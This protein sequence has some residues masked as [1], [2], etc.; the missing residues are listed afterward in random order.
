M[1]P[2]NPFSKAVV[3][4]QLTRVLASKGFAHSARMARFLRFT[5]ERA[6]EGAADQLKEYV[7][8]I[9]VFDRKSSYDPRVDPIVRVEARRLRSKLKNYYANE[10]LTDHVI[11]EF[12]TG[13]YAPQFLCGNETPA[14]DTPKPRSIAVLPFSNL[15]AEPDTEYFSD[16]LTEE[17]IHG[18]TKLEGLMVVA[19]NS[20]ARLKGEPHNWSEIGR[21]LNVSTV[22]VGSVRRRSAIGR[23][24]DVNDRPM[25]RT[26]ANM[27]SPACS[28]LAPR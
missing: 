22:L 18:L 25:S 7:L 3:E 2:E 16:G 6:L 9:E 19:W 20:A 26:N 17:L 4:N 27:S 14:H 5:V 24:A 8:G 10:G 15:S 1:K 13:T 11:I 23:Y 28:P 21:Q 12:P